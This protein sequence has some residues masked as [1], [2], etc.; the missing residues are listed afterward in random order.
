VEFFIEPTA[1]ETLTSADVESFLFT[2]GGSDHDTVDPTLPLRRREQ[3]YMFDRSVP[4]NIVDWNINI[5]T[6]VLGS[7]QVDEHRIWMIIRSSG[8]WY[9]LDTPHGEVYSWRSNESGVWTLQPIL[10]DFDNNRVLDANDI[11][12]LSREVIAPTPDL[13]FDLNDDGQ[14]SS[15]D[16]TIWVHDIRGTYFGDANLNGEFNGSDMVQVFAAGKYETGENAGW[17][18]G[19]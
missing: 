16:H 13:V 4:P 15:A 11:D 18:E 3:T 6:Y 5:E 8:D 2:I 7:T 17:S 19:D 10:G 1:G 14:V 9:N 12:L